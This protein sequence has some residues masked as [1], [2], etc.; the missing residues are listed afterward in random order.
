M[1]RRPFALALSAIGASLAFATAAPA[2]AETVKV[3]LRGFE[4]VPAVSTPA[5]GELRLKISDKK[6]VIE[7]ELDYENLQGDITQSHIHVGQKGVAGGISIWLCQTA[8]NP[9]P[10]AV[11]A[12][13]PVCPGPRTGSVDGTITSTNV[14]GPAGQLITAGQLDEVIAAI[15][16]GV[17]YGNVH[18][19]AVG[20][21]E[22]RGQLH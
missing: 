14:V 18:T 5:S 16:A 7:Y 20:S 4:E 6:G 1:H 21:G 3:H 22:I 13:T 19:T 2:A 17:A 9:A 15:R 11:A 10:A 8:T 12:L